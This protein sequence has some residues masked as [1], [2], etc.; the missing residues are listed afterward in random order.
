LTAIVT[1][2]HTLVFIVVAVYFHALFMPLH[3]PFQPLCMEVCR[4]GVEPV[5]NGGFEVLVIFI[6]LS[7]KPQLLQLFGYSEILQ[8]EHGFTKVGQIE[9][10]G[11]LAG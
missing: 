1:Y 7:S 3:Q 10:F 11:P 4:L 9:A 8:L 6:S 5:H 2:K